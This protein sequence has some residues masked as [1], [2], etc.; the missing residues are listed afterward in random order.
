MMFVAGAGVAGVASFY[1]WRK[2]AARRRARPGTL[3]D[4]RDVASVEALVRSQD[5]GDGTDALA[6]RLAA[7]FRAFP[8]DEG[9]MRRLSVMQQRHE[10]EGGLREFCVATVYAVASAHLAGEA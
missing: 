9:V 8:P 2:H 5:R 1:L 4:A 7:V 10:G 3:V 6:A